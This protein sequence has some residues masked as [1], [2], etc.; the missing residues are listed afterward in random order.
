MKYFA[1][2]LKTSWY[3]AKFVVLSFTLVQSATVRRAPHVRCLTFS[4]ILSVVPPCHMTIFERV[5]NTTPDVSAENTQKNDLETHLQTVLGGH[6]QIKVADRPISLKVA[7]DNKP[8]KWTTCTYEGVSLTLKS[9][10][11]NSVK[12]KWW[13]RLERG[14]WPK[15][16]KKWRKSCAKF[17][18][19]GRTKLRML[20]PLH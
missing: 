12:L 3:G 4:F 11:V 7:R 16:Q 10:D 19:F 18:K 15:L 9:L 2:G 5:S 17:S 8:Q 14:G 6:L 13:S 20:K 1:V